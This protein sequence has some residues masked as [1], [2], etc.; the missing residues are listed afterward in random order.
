MY[1]T[2]WKQ[3]SNY[4]GRH[5]RT[6]RQWHYKR[7]TMPFLRSSE[8]KRGKIKI[9]PAV[10]D[11]WLHTIFALNLVANTVAKKYQFK[12]KNKSPL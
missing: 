3:I 9:L 1:L 6:V 12:D 7:L 11:Q 10:I 4:I 5:E 2:G 8:N